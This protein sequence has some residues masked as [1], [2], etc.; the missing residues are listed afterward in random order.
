MSAGCR[1]CLPDWRKRATGGPDAQG[2]ERYTLGDLWD[3]SSL[4]KNG[5]LFWVRGSR[6][7]G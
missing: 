5:F 2:L 4:G 6:L 7:P 1:D 3:S